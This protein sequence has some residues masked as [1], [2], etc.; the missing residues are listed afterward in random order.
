MKS[1][2]DF[3]KGRQGRRSLVDTLALLLS[4]SR[5]PESWPE[6]SFTELQT[7][8]SKLQ[9]YNIASSTIRS[10]IYSRRELFESK[11]APDGVIRWRLSD[12]ARKKVKS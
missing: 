6:M 9:H 12:L 2:T 10:A 8:A 4:K 7:A 3:V 5:A 11:R 1:P